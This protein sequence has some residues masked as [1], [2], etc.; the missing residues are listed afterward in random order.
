MR[1]Y[2]VTAILL[3]DI[4]Q[5][6]RAHSGESGCGRSARADVA[7]RHLSSRGTEVHLSHRA[8]FRVVEDVTVEHPH[9]GPLVEGHEKSDSGVDRHVERV[10]PRHWMNRLEVF[11][12]RKEEKPVE[13]ERVS[14]RALIPD[15]PDLRLAERREKRLGLPEWH[16]VD[17]ELRLPVGTGGRQ[18]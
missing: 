11:V 16:P 2:K 1:E 13:V 3:P 6:H 8:A 18:A 10:L 12:E 14:E 7:L 5:S 17:V 9:A 4:R 15:R